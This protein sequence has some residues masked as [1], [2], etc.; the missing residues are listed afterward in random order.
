MIAFYIVFFILVALSAVA[1]FFINKKLVIPSTIDGISPIDATREKIAKVLCSIWMSLYFINLFLPN[2]FAMRTF[3]DISPYVSGENIYF[4]IFTWFNDVAFLVLPIAIFLKNDTFK[5]IA[6]YFCL[7]VCLINAAFFFK[8]I[9]FYTDAAHSAG[10]KELRFF[11]AETKAFFTNF[12][13][14]TIYFAVMFYLEAL[15]LMNIVIFDRKKIL[16][17]FKTKNVLTFFAVLVALI[18]SILPIY[19]PQYIFKGYAL[20]TENVFSTF[21]FGKFY[22]IGWI[23]FTIL[24]GVVLTLIFRK[25]SYEIRYIVVLCLGLSLLLQYNEMFTGIG[26]ITASRM[27]FQL[28]NMAAF[29]ILLTLLTKSEKMYHFTLAINSVG[30]FI[31]MIICDTSPFGVTYIMSIH[32]M[33]EHTNVILTPLMCAT[34]AIFKPLK[35]KDIKDFVIL[36]TGLFLFL[37]ALGGTFTGLYDTTGND[38]WR[39]NYLFMFDKEKTMAIAGFSG[40]LFDL[41]VTIG[42]FFTLSMI[43]L[44]MYVVFLAICIGAFCLFYAFFREKKKVTLDPAMSVGDGE[45]PTAPVEEQAPANDVPDVPSETDDPD[46]N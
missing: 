36:F 24:E 25:K 29:F 28:C 21:S 15:L 40:K 1:L 31:A 5:K 23:L 32:Y 18:F 4:A 20:S 2:A 8:Y 41:K 16:P 19:A 3:D 12:T 33:V 37:L 22:H 26:E 14:R 7:I 30:A 45:I 44:M 46:K 27:P 13:F 6:S 38:F 17:V 42:G 39:C 43:H 10:I 9:G 11:S 35:L 34:L